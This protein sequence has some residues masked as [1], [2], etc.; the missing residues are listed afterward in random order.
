MA[1]R[2][3]FTE[4]IKG[5]GGLLTAEPLLCRPRGTRSAAR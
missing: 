5:K 3:L 4:S 2:V 1:L